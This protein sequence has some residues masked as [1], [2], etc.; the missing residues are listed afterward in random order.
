MF[1]ACGAIAR[2]G[3][4]FM[5]VINPLLAGFQVSPESVLLK[6]LPQA[7][8]Y[9]VPECCGSLTKLDSQHAD[10]DRPEVTAVQFAPPL[11]LKTLLLTSPS[12]RFHSPAMA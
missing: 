3:L 9:S 6:T 7:I 10:E 1:E 4:K 8:T 12:Y 2:N 5:L 11:L